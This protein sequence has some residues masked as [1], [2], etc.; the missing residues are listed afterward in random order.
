M[1]LLR[2]TQCTLR[3]QLALADHVHEFNSGES[4]RGGP[5]GFEPHHRPH[6]S[7]DGSVVLFD[8]VVQIFDPTDLDVRPMFC[9]AAFDRRRVGAALVD[10]DLLGNAMMADRLAR[11]PQG[12]ITIP[13]GGQGSGANGASEA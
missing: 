13:L 9:V 8:D 6:H 2:W 11:E 7:F 5:N 4:C 3:A 12:G 1:E 10:R